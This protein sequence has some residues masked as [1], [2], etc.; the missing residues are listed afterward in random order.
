M[1]ESMCSGIDRANDKDRLEKFDNAIESLVDLAQAMKK[2]PNTVNQLKEVIGDLVISKN[3]Y[4]N[5]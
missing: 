5:R 3:I 2:Y 4:K 1:K